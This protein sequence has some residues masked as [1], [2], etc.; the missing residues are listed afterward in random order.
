[1]IGFSQFSTGLGRGPAA[2]DDETTNLKVLNPVQ[3][4]GY[5]SYPAITWQRATMVLSV[6]I[7]YVTNV[8]FSLVSL[9][10]LNIVFYS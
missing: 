7:L 4:F 3:G 8:A 1:M 9:S 5:L 10:T 6:T 2:L